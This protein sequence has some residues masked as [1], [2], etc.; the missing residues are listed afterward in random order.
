LAFLH[1][2]LGLGVGDG[3][4]VSV[5]LGVGE[6]VIVVVGVFVG[7]GL[8]VWEGVGVSVAVGVLVAVG[9]AVSGGVFV[10][11]GTSAV[12]VAAA[13]LSTATCV[14]TRSGVG[15]GSPPHAARISSEIR[16]Q[17]FQKESFIAIS[18]LSSEMNNQKTAHLP[19][20]QALLLL[21]GDTNGSVEQSL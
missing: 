21:P 3:A 12:S 1:V 15:V 8:G 14:P 4:G 9:V 10:A 16:Q 11:V 13:A 7:L 6:G 5:G 19:A 2:T 17:S 20:R 18:P